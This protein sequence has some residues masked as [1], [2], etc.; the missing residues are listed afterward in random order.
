VGR[1]PRF[2]EE[3]EPARVEPELRRPPG[4]AAFGDVGPVLLGG[5]QR[6]F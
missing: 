4:R 6:F 5:P 2:V 1:S 3:H